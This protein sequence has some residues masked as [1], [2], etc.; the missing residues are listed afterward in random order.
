MQIRSAR[1]D[2]VDPICNAIRRSI[3][4]LCV[5]DH[6]ERDDILSAWL[7]NKT[8]ENIRHWITAPLQLTVVAEIDG[9]IAGV[10][11]VS[12]E[13]KIL[14]NYVSPD[15]RFR[16]VSK[17]VMQAMEEHLRN[18]GVAVAQL[19]S[20]GTAR[21]FYQNLGYV[22]IGEPQLWRAGQLSY[23]MEKRLLNSTLL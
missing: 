10:G 17:A 7:A 20:T 19:V 3:A 6:K 9:N 8:P 2:D 18:S 23:P 5:E 22:Q 14:L 16:G 11:Q 12:S 13:G 21:R 4:E 15:F 1:T